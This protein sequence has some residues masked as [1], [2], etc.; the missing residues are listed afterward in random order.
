MSVEQLQRLAVVERKLDIYRCLIPVATT[1]V[2]T[3]VVTTLTVII[4]DSENDDDVSTVNMIEHAFRWK[5]NETTDEI[6]H[7]RDAFTRSSNLH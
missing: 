2:V 7:R 6:R 3:P 4:S 1:L 5:P